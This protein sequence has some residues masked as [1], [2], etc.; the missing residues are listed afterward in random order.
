[1][2]NRMRNRDRSKPHNTS[3]NNGSDA[4]DPSRSTLI[5]AKSRKTFVRSAPPKTS[6]TPSTSAPSASGIS[7]DYWFPT[8]GNSLAA[9]LP[10]TDFITVNF[11]MHPCLR[12]DGRPSTL[13]IPPTRNKWISFISSAWEGTATSFSRVLS[14]WPCLPIVQLARNCWNCW[15]SSWPCRTTVQLVRHSWNNSRT[16]MDLVV[17]V[18]FFI[19]TIF[20]GYIALEFVLKALPGVVAQAFD[21]NCSVVYVT[22]PGPIITVSLVAASPTNPA[23]GTYYFSVVNSTTR[24]LNSIAPPSR[25][26]TLIT[27]TP[28]ITPI[29]SSLSATGSSFPGE[30][31][32]SSTEI[33][34]S[35]DLSIPGLS[36]SLTVPLISGSTMVS[37]SMSRP[38]TTVP[39]PS[40]SP[41]S[42]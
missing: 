22:V 36:S 40:L 1:M 11:P 26:S 6:N 41:S 15:L 19:A 14:S 5:E 35:P 28:E 13:Q 30:S 20:A 24:W 25:F 21:G 29:V 4:D 8:S 18:I 37:L 32:V 2:A 17:T 39:L 7:L 16:S 42:L 33:Y 12:E 10:T 3:T 38:D 31:S 9:W 23:R 34:T 27:R